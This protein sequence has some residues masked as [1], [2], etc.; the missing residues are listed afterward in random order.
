MKGL[1]VNLQH[2]PSA[3]FFL[4]FL[5]TVSEVLAMAFHT[6]FSEPLSTGLEVPWW[7]TR[8]NGAMLW[9]REEVQFTLVKWEGHCMF[10]RKHLMSFVNYDMDDTSP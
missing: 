2:T 1:L 8:G 3:H 10:K 4:F 5:C 7:V 9:T 6:H